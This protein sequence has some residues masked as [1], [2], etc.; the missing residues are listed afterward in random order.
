MRKITQYDLSWL[1]EPTIYEVNCL[2][3]H[4]D[5]QLCEQ[6]GNELSKFLLNGI[7]DFQYCE[8]VSEVKFDWVSSPNQ[9]E[10]KE[11]IKVPSHMQM[12]GFGNPQYVNT[13]YPWDGLENIKPPQIPQK[14]NPVGIY[15]KVFDIPGS[16]LNQGVRISFQGVESCFYLWVNGAFIGY[17]ENS[18]CPAE[19]DLTPFLMEKENHIYV[20]VVRFCSGSWLEDQDFFRF[21]GIF[22]DIY[23]YPVSR[24]FIEDLDIKS[25][26]KDDFSQGSLTV[27]IRVLNNSTT[28]QEITLCAFLKREEMVLKNDKKLCLHPGE[29]VEK[30]EFTV[31][32]PKLWSAEEPNLYE[33]FLSVYDSNTEEFITAVS[34][35]TG[36]RRFEMKN[37]IMYLNGKRI[38]F[39]GVNRHEFHPKYGRAITSAEILEDIRI[40][41]QNNINAVRTSH[42]PNNSEFYRLCDEYGLYVIDETNL[43]THGTWQVM[44]TV[45]SPNPEKTVPYDNPLWLDAVLSRGQSMLERDKNHPSILMWSCGNEAF[46]GVVI[47]SLSDWFRQRDNSRLVHYEG[48]FHDRRYSDTSDME[49]R[50]YAKVSEIE[51]Y[52]NQAPTKPFILCEYTHAMG[53]SLG[54]MQKY[55]EL[56]NKYPMYQGGFIW[57]FA[58]QALTKTTSNGKTFFAVGGDF[59]DRPN[60][61]YF[62]GN[63]L[64]FADRTPTPKL[65]EVKYLYQPVRIT[66]KAEEIVIE[67]RNLFKDTSDYKFLWRILRE[68][69]M[70]YQADF[71]FLVP[72]GETLSYQPSFGSFVDFAK[73]LH[74]KQIYLDNK[75][76]EQEYV[77]ECSMVLKKNCL[78]AKANY[79]V[80]FGQE[81]LFSI[82]K[83]AEK[84][85]ASIVAGDCNVGI[86]MKN[87]FALL[88]KVNGKLISFKKNG[89]E[90]IK[91]GISP[92]FWRAPT[93]ND[94][95]NNSTF[96]WA[97]WKIAS[98]YQK[99]TDIQ[100]NEETCEIT[101]F[102]E[103]PTNPVIGIK[104]TYHFFEND[105]FD[106]SMQVNGSDSEAP[107]F[108]I[109]FIMAECYKKIT[110]YGNSQEEAYCDRESG[111]RLAHCTSTVKEQYISYLR[112]QECGNKTQVRS[113]SIQDQDGDG[114][115]ITGETPLEATALAFTSHE[116]EAAVN[117]AALPDIEKTVVGVYKKK[118]GVAGDDSWGAPILDEYKLQVTEDLELKFTISAL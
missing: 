71:E 31:E 26:L 20:M 47:K 113:F 81:I 16:F 94:L 39:R 17:R 61:G 41:K 35:K 115:M 29:S 45:L 77:L 83:S 84:K 23:L 33:V 103:V 53:N 48:I 69:E 44:G 65:K 37:Q 104:M 55:T 50:M 24:T 25:V 57:D 13:M 100:I 46:G 82:K 38:V 6:D 111:C 43:E 28:D 93:D 79:E 114:I 98:L 102:Y 15:H 117:I 109:N 108:G 5:H 107:S 86:Q 54:G 11:H 85:V 34:T 97:N 58:D 9:I 75:R 89:K 106:V 87:S 4:S 42:Y 2:P 116:I 30:I 10:F 59:D 99:C 112:P 88:S 3:P 40:I 110:W 52:L 95:G 96:Q 19:F 56:E 36:F 74:E 51:E 66:C 76:E 27:D 80:S 90:Y 18:F 22:R 8:N 101:C 91:Q 63:G 67:N 105:C 73:E 14:F 70:V 32:E 7:W 49:S 12:E 92:D 1:E 60:D 68:G 21:S 72:A 62:C 64:L 78:W 118:A